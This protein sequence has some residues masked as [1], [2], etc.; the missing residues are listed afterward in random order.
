MAPRV[1]TY[2]GAVCDARAAVQFVRAK[3]GELGLIPS[4]S[5]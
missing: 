4:A 5:G 3:A 1:K 2:P